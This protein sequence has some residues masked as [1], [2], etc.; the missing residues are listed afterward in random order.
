MKTAEQMP[1][2]NLSAVKGRRRLGARKR[3]AGTPKFS[4]HCEIV[5]G[6]V[7]TDGQDCTERG[8]HTRAR[9]L[10]RDMSGLARARTGGK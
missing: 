3:G 5:H 1:D 6:R 10:P 4:R 9:T 8:L 7:P 2:G